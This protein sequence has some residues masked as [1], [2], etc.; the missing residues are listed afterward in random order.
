V[1][2]LALAQNSL[3]GCETN[4]RVGKPLTHYEVDTEIVQMIAGLVQL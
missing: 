3:L 1:F 2:K 4:Q